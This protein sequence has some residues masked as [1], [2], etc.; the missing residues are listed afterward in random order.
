MT[1]TQLIA[2][3]RTQLSHKPLAYQLGFLQAFLAKIM[4]NDTKIA[5]Q[6][7]QQADEVR[8]RP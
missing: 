8:K 5:H 6:F 7:K 1:Q 2:Y 4:Y 3:I